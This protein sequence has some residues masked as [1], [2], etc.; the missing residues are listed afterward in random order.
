ME[1]HPRNQRYKDQILNA[2]YE[3]CIER[4]R[5]YTESYRRTEGEHP[6]LRAA[7]A[8]VH[9]VRQ[10]S[11]QIY[12]DESIVGNRSSKV[13]GTVIPVERGDSNTVLEL[14][15]D[16]LTQR[17]MQPFVISEADRRE[18]MDDI[19]PYWKG[20][21]LRARKNRLWKKNGL[22]FRPG[23]G[24]ASLAKRKKRLDLVRLKRVVEVPRFSFKHAFRG[25]TELLYNN[26]ALVMNAFD[27]QGHMIVGHKNILAQGWAGVQS[28]AELRLAEAQATGDAEG[29]A[30]LE[31]VIL[32]CHGIRDLAHRFAQKAEDLAAQTTDPARR[33]ELARIAERCLHVP[34]HPPRDFREAVQALWLTQVGALVAYGMTGIFAIG[35]FDQY[36]YPYYQKDLDAGRLTEAEGRA[37][38]EELLLKLSYNLLLLPYVGKKTSNELG[39]DSCSPTV[40]GVTRAGEDAVNPLSYTI[41]DA[42][43]NVKATGNSFT[44]RLSEQTPKAFWRRALATFRSTSGAALYCD[45]QCIEALKGCGMSE[46][47]ARDYGV[48]GCVEPTGDGD[49][50]GCTSGNDISF[51]AALDMALH[52]GYLTIM[53]RHIGPRTGDPRRFAGFDQLMDAFKQQVLFMIRTVVKAVNLKDEAYR[54]AFPNPYVSAT[55]R[56]CVDRAR[57]M[58]WGGADYNFGSLSARGLG[59]ATDSLAAIAHFVYNGGGLSMD[60]LVTHLDNN[61]A[62]AETLRNRLLHRAPKYGCDDDRADDIAREIAEFFCREVATHQTLRGGPFRPSFFSYGMHVLEGAILGATANGRLAGEPVSN[63]FSP[64]NGSESQGPTAMLRSVSKIDH[65]LISNGC[66]LNMKLLPALFAGEERL[67]KMVALVKGFFAQGGMEIQPNVVS[68]EMLMDAQKHPDRYRDLVVRV[69][70]YSAYF[71]DLGKPL[72]D[73]IISRTE[74][75]KL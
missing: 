70:G 57:D 16:F 41:L 72:Q 39:A 35:R 21:T 5:Y 58:T 18:L 22:F 3:I 45:E 68:N 6:A 29:R 43:E 40:G 50:F 37:L 32:S 2:P 11:I 19:L 66:A 69:S 62:G 71:T 53:G 8:F 26:I 38:M 27:V 73:E 61:F 67:D 56:G 25:I 9:T 48:I 7:K 54:Q 47:D 15:L 64:S 13:V 75:G 65:H 14:E 4:A 24:P 52:D 59:T 34:Y 10:M 44:I 1:I 23:L 74:F 60:T 55:L 51:T 46:E 30:F 49:T 36:L 33:R 42:F 63:S 28:R 20:R 31:A 17:E 12:P